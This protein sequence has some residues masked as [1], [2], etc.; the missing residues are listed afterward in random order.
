MLHITLKI[1]LMNLKQ[2]M[3]KMKKNILMDY[4]HLIKKLKKLKIKRSKEI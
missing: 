1:I 3:K 2:K 4:L